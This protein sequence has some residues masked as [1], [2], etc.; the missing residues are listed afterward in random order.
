MIGSHNFHVRSGLA[1]KEHALVWKEPVDLT[2]YNRLGFTD[3]AESQADAKALGMDY[4]AITARYLTDDK[5]GGFTR[6]NPKYRDL[7]ELRL[8][9][10]GGLNATFAGIHN[11]PILL[12]YPNL[13]SEVEALIE[14]K[15]KKGLGAK[16]LNWMKD[17]AYDKYD[18]AKISKLKPGAKKILNF[19]S[20]LRDFASRLL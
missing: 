4:T 9:F 20:P 19:L 13:R 7:I 2:C 8:R 1:D 3:A 6:I 17:R 16:A 15:P 12:A 14:A 5:T 11:K 10:W 18:P